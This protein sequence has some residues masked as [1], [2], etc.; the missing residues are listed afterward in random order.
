MFAN[1]SLVLVA[2]SSIFFRLKGTLSED[3]GYPKEKYPSKHLCPECYETEGKFDEGKVLDYL[4]R[5][6]AHPKRTQNLKGAPDKASWGERYRMAG[7]EAPAA[8][9]MSGE[10]QS[11]SQRW[12]GYFSSADI[13]LFMIVYVS[14]ACLLVLGYVHFKV[15]GR[16]RWCNPSIVFR[17]VFA[18]SVV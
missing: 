6:Y 10:V 2:R 8:V 9:I 16:R 7:S 5:I 17:Q 1:F 13:W 18:Q 4:L 3:P 15:V 12:L 11:K 14:V